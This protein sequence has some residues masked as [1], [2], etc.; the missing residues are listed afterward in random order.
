[1][2]IGHYALGLGAKR[3]VPQVSLGALL[4]LAVVEIANLF[5]P[6]PPSITAVT[7]PAEAMWL[8][9]LWGY[10]VDRHR[11]PVDRR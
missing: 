1:M 4:F 7:Y 5:G 6:P 3:L 9:V 2:F 11:E 10:W 8:L